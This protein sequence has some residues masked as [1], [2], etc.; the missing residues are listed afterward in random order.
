[1]AKVIPIKPLTSWSFSRYSDYKR[2]PL[3]AKL[4]H[5][6]KIQEPKNAAMQR[7]ADIHDQA[8]KFIKG[9]L[10]KLPVEL[11]PMAAE[12][13]LMKQRYKKR[14]QSMVVEDNWAFTKD[15][16]ETAWNNWTAC[17]V[18][19]KLDCAHHEDEDHAGRD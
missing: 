8:E 10:P 11:K 5:I 1:M 19:I 16:E 14:S 12:F 9:A 15:W 18:R 4:K 17:W 7:G 6:D 3:S 13:K 2:C